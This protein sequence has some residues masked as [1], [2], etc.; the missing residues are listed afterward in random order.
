M[1]RLPGGLRRALSAGRWLPILGAGVSASAVTEDEKHPPTWSKL[2]AALEADLPGRVPAG[3]IDAL[4]AYA[5]T[6]GRSYLVERLGEL[7]YVNDIQPGEAHVAFAKLP[8]DTVVTTN[9]DFLMEQGYAGQRRPCVPLIGES[10]LAMQPR[11]EATYLLKFHGDLNHPDQLVVTEEDYDGFVRRNPLLVTYL[12]GRLLSREPIFIGYSLDDADMR[13]ILGLL[14]ERLGRMT[15][16]SWAILPT[17]PDDE[18]PKFRRRGIKA[19]VLEERDP[20]ADRASVLAK[21]FNELR[22]VWQHDTASQLTGRNDAT[23]AELRR[24]PIAPQLALV[25]AS[26]SLLTLYREYLFPVVR[27]TGLLPLGVD[28]VRAQDL[29][30]TPMAIDMALSKAAVVIYD[31]GRGNSLP[32]DYVINRRNG[33]PEA[34]VSNPSDP[35]LAVALGADTIQRPSEMGTWPD[36]FVHNLLNRISSQKP[37]LEAAD[38]GDNLQ[39]LAD[40]AESDQLLWTC[41]AL[42]ESQLREKGN[43]STNEGESPILPTTVSVVGPMAALREHFAEDFEVVIQGVRLRHDMMQNLSVAPRDLA[44]TAEMLLRVVQER[45]QLQS[46]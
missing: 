24:N 18:A 26:R 44:Q 25:I 39:R 21:F 38:L 6:Y 11:P 46:R 5:D 22:D 17:D 40:N 7:L 2:A 12:S 36:T 45:L 31:L 28:D 37:S 33:A 43:P 23:T 4:S 14:R 1:R 3:P 15:R 42:L 9:I 35:G 10:Q 34:I 16:P 20:Q 29:A 13:E 41:L 8:F 27:K 30:M 32:L 19:I